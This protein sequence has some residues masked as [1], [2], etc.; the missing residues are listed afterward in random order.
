M[1]NEIVRLMVHLSIV[2]AI[3]RCR[4]RED[5][6]LP[7]TRANNVFLYLVVADNERHALAFTS[8]PLN[9]QLLDTFLP[10]AI[11]CRSQTPITQTRKSTWSTFTLHKHETAEV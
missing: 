4:D 6:R 3:S 10:S 5:I 7:V 9:Q 1:Y 8:C 2:S 11:T